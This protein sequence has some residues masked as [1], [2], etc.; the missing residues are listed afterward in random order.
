MG[1]IQIQFDMDESEDGNN[2]GTYI[3]NG[4]SNSFHDASADTCSFLGSIVEHVNSNWLAT[5]SPTSWMARR[6][7]G[8]R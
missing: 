7:I 6:P 2:Q 4:S 3:N 5:D 8:F 1:D